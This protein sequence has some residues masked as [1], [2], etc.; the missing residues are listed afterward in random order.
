MS[1]Y[2]VA[3]IHLNLIACCGANWPN[4]LMCRLPGSRPLIRTTVSAPFTMT[5]KAAVGF[6]SVFRSENCYR[7]YSCN[8]KAACVWGDRWRLLW[9]EWWTIRLLVVP[10]LSEYLSWLWV[11]RAS[12]K[13]NNSQRALLWSEF[14]TAKDVRFAPALGKY[15]KSIVAI[16]LC[17]ALYDP[18]PFSPEFISYNGYVQ[19][20]IC[21]LLSSRWSHECAKR[22]SRNSLRNIPKIRPS[23]C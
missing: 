20:C 5:S 21:L 1:A 15:Q 14:S 9:I 19:W 17:V 8:R 16:E 2:G 11:F 22:S 6:V 4:G 3:A 23:S 10:M 13:P 12:G 18:S 7:K